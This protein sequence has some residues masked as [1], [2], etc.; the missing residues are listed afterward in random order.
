[1]SKGDQKPATLGDLKGYADAFE[2]AM[3]TIMGRL[4]DANASLADRVAVLEVSRDV[5]T[6]KANKPRLIIK[7]NGKPRLVMR[8]P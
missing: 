7:N 3:A 8:A 2:R 6:T 1:M 5:E 4:M